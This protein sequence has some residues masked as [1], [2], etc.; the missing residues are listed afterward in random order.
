MSYLWDIQKFGGKFI[1]AC[2][3]F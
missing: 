3:L 2:S 1:L